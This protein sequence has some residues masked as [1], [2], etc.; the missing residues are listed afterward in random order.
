MDRQT[1]GKEG[2]KGEAGEVKNLKTFVLSSLESSCYGRRDRVVT[3][4]IIF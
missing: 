1:E 2:R 4:M 3:S